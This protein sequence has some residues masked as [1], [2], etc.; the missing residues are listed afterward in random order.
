MI[1]NHVRQ[2]LS[3]TLALT[4]AVH[5][6]PKG[7]IV[8]KVT[9]KVTHEPLMAANVLIEG[10]SLGTSSDLAGNFVIS[11]L[12]EGVYRVRASYVGYKTVVD[13]LVPVNEDQT[14]V[15][16][17]A[18]QAVT[19]ET[20]PVIITAQASGQDQAINQQLSATQIMNAVSAARIQELPDANA[21]ESV[22][23]LPGVSMV[24]SGGEANEIVVRG[25]QPK[26]NAIMVDGVRMASS[27]PNDRSSDLSMISPN[28]LD[29]IE[30]SKTVTPDQDADVLGGTVNFKTREA[31][32]SNEMEPLRLELLVQGGYTGLPDAYNDYR[33]EKYVGSIE[34]RFLDEKLGVFAQ[35]DYE[36]RN[37]TSNEL[38][39]VYDESSGSFDQYVTNSVNLHYIDRDRQRANGVLNLD[40]RLPEGKI[41]LAN[42]L[43]SGTTYSEDRGETFT[44]HQGNFAN[45]KNYT[46]GYT[47]STVNTITSTLGVEQQVSTFHLNAKLSQVYAETKDP[48]DWTATWQQ[49]ADAG[50]S[51]FVNRANINPVDIVNAANNNLATTNMHDFTNSNSFSRELAYTA[52]LDVDVLENISSMINSV[53]KFGGKYRYQ[54]RSYV[55]EQFS[56]E[57]PFGGT[58]TTTI[59]DAIESYFSLPVGGG[60]PISDFIEPN[61]SYGKYLDGNYSMTVPL[62]YE[63]MSGL[64][65]Y[66]KNLYPT[67]G[68]SEG[69]GRNNYLSST[70][71]YSGNEN[72]AALY[73]MA[74][75]NVG[76]LVTIVPGV[77][78]QDLQTQYT[79]TR[80]SQT[81][82]FW[83]NYPHADTTITVDHGYW[84]PDVN[85]RYKPLTWMDVRLSYT[86]SLAYPDYSSIIPRSDVGTGTIAYN[87]PYLSPTR[88]TNYDANV[89]FYG[90]T[91]GLFTVGGFYKQIH[92]LIYATS[93]NVVGAAAEP[94]ILYRG[95]N[96]PSGGYTV[97]TYVNDPYHIYEYGFEFD[98][99]THFWYLPD[100]LAGLVLNVNYTHIYSRAEY[101]FDYVHPKDPSNFRSPLITDTTYYVDRLFDQPDDIVNLSLGFDHKGFSIRISM[102]YQ[103]DVSAGYAF[104]P[105]LRATTAAYKRWDLSAK[106][107]LPWSGVQLYGSINNLNGARDFSMLQMYPSI[108][109]SGQVYGM[110]ADLGVRWQM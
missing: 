66:L 24:R 104:W 23:R 49:P 47:A 96:P 27:N 30:V 76:P 18:L 53:I 68:P 14:T 74:T 70:N 72:L 20:A 65:G 98:W 8:G 26:Y 95:A 29:G 43:S 28:M 61:F 13:S 103:S 57:Q 105:Q 60:I 79:G 67:V 84:L 82:L 22:G 77:R 93:F 1:A 9:D 69:Y 89:S 110:S 37:L 75:V 17:F 3:L 94:Y 99:Q 108:P 56:D 90:N 48:Q 34:D 4:M 62:S 40:Y 16:N 35:A 39:N 15:V 92:D 59:T 12:P 21:A 58:S 106:Q 97:N 19:M 50:I 42:F 102:L 73:V 80:G 63:K 44:T 64:S 81:V 41:T 51:Q 78:Y 100:P 52:S 36:R 25:M 45:T 10:T 32:A 38:S 11:L 31:K 83:S 54:T 109:V 5:A 88:S 101:P 46:L 7:K 33:N 85:L 107:N 2:I 55:N 87:N 6:A 71:N 91:I 86:N